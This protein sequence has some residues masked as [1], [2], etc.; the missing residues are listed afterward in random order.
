MALKDNE[1]LSVIPNRA[2]L[3]GWNQTRFQ[4]E[5]EALASS[6]L[7]YVRVVDE[8]PSGGFGGSSVVSTWQL[9]DLNTITHNDGSIASLAANVVTLPAGTYRFQISVPGY[10][11]NEHKARLNNT[12]DAI[13]YLGTNAAASAGNGDSSFVTGKFV[14]TGDTD[15]QVEQWTNAAV[16][17]NGL[18]RPTFIPAVNELYTVVE[19][20]QLVPG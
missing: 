1:L 15:F 7:R 5:V 13:T 16:A 20:F 18:G 2:G 10:A 8:K 12:T 11:V 9:R 6:G 14:L 19:F 17:N 4:E 3:P